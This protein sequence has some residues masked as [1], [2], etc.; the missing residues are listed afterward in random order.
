MKHG[1]RNI[2]N[3]VPGVAGCLNFSTMT[4]I[5]ECHTNIGHIHTKASESS[6]LPVCFNPRRSLKFVTSGKVIEMLS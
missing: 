5:T 6:S 1:G 3:I 2:K 4:L